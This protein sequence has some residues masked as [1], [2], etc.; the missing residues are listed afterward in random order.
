M[1]SFEE[2]EKTIAQLE[3]YD[4]ATKRAARSKIHALVKDAG[5]ARRE[6]DALEQTL[7]GYIDR[8]VAAEAEL[9]AS[10]LRASYVPL[11]PPVPLP[12]EPTPEMVDVFGAAWGR[13][14]GVPMLERKPGDRTRAGLRAVLAVLNDGRP[15]F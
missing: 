13:L 15:V 4:S 2:V 10:E 6:A 1:T 14:D 3:S 7:N 11:P 5:L 12:A 8:A 9:K